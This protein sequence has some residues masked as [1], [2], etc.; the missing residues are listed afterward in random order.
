VI[1]RERVADIRVAPRS[2]E[3]G[4]RRTGAPAAQHTPYGQPHRAREIVGLIEAA[5]TLAPPMKRH[6]HNRVSACEH[7]AAMLAHQPAERRGEHA[8]TVV[9]QRVNDFPKR[10]IVPAAAAGERDQ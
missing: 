10:P 8:T 2:W 9:F 4:L 5:L 7:V 1:E 3:A 6:R